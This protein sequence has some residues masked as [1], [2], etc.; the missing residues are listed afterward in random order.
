[1]TFCGGEEEKWKEGSVV[2]AKSEISS[3][4]ARIHGRSPCSDSQVA[5]SREPDPM[6]GCTRISEPDHMTDVLELVPPSFDPFVAPPSQVVCS[7][8]SC[9]ST[10]VF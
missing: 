1:M 10:G 5:A 8:V 9:E 4:E 7:Q 6:S 2:V 3:K